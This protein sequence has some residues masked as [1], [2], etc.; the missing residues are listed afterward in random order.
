MVSEYT[1]A[2]AAYV[3]RIPKEVSFSQAAPILCAGVTTYKALKETEAKAGQWVAVMGACGGL[4][5]VGC[6]YAKAMGLR[7]VA[8]DFGEEKRDYALNTLKCDAFVD[9]K[10]GGVSV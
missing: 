4:G 3:G 5:H 7:V 2:E 8:V 1:V 6:Q 10:V 9:V